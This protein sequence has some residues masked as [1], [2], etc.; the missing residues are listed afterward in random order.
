[1]NCGICHRPHHAKKLPFLCAVDA[2]NRLYESRVEHA[3][4]L[5]KNEEAERRVE[6]ALPSQERGGVSRDQPRQSNAQ[7]DRLRDEEA[8]AR[9]RT[10][11]IIAQADRLKSEVDAARREI[12][13]KR[14]AIARKKSDLASLSAGTST[15]RNRQLEEVERSTQ[16][17]RYKWN[18]SAD[19]MAATRAFLCEGSARLY[20]LRQVKKGSVKRYEIGGVEIFDLHAMNSLSPEAISTSLAHIAHILVLA[21][22]YLGIRLPAEITPPHPDYPRP[23][24]FPLAT[25]YKH[26]EVSFP[27]SLASQMPPVT[28]DD[29]EQRRVSRPRPLFIDKPLPTLAKEDPSAYSFFLEGASLLA[30]DIAWACCSQGV[31]FGDKDSHEDVCNM[32]Q[33]LWR[34]LIGDQLHRRSVE[35]TFPSSP[36]PPPIGSPRDEDR[37]EI[38]NPKSTI[39]RWSHGTLHSFLGG[40][41]GTEFVRSFKIVPP[42]KL[43]DR[44][45]KRLSSEAPMLEWEKIEGDELEDNFDDG[46]LVRGHGSGG[47]AAA[48]RG[49]LGVASILTVRAVGSNGGASDSANTAKGTSGWT[50]LKNR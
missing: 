16:R 1:M 29:G 22:H 7:V 44:L 46:V 32:G 31:S 8:A 21:A 47:S 45:K 17:L 50:R 35:P 33:N 9:D 36:T 4:A 11:Q 26:G 25:S 23:T 27:G 15:R 38:T 6:A 13:E 43:A 19:T 28:G 24:I 30:H 18:R 49:D 39:G 48:G 3:Q 41:E 2:R 12:A 42:L 40:A 34:L 37:G 10:S 14:D 5:I 20:G